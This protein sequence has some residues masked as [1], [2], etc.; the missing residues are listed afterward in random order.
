MPELYDPIAPVFFLVFLMDAFIAWGLIF[1]YLSGRQ[2]S[3]P[4]SH[5]IGILVGSTIFAIGIFIYFILR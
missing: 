3:E 5:F 2:F 1:Q 4:L